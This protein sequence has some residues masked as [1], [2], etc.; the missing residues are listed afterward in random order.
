MRAVV[1]DRHGGPD[2]LRP[3]ERQ[4][5][6]PG[7][8]QVL[9]EVAAAG[10]NYIDVYHRT[11]SYPTVPPFVPGVEGAG[12]VSATGEG[13]TTPRVGDLVAW[14]GPPG[15]YAEQV[16]LPADRVVVVPDGISA[17]DAAAVMLQGLTAHYLTHATYPV[18]PGDTVLVH[19]A[20]GGVG[21][22]LI[23]VV[24]LLGGRVIGT[25]STAE[26]EDLA[27]RA[28]ADEVIRYTEVDFAERTRELTDGVG[29][30]AV[31]DGVG[32]TTFDGSMAS[33]RPRGVLALYGQASGA[34]PQLDLQR[35]NDHGSLF[36]TRP[37]LV[38]HV[39]TR[40]ELRERADAM[41]GWVADGRLTIRVG[42]RYPLAD[43][44]TAHTELEA[45][46]TTGKLLLL[47]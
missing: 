12:T 46:R 14:A 30:A 16:A 37:S 2:V 40:Q 22:L 13:V 39:A 27:R 34:V 25:V 7:P 47:P 42:H 44:A 36:V 11:G 31:Y 19:A 32:R 45:R 43:A 6:E 21:L 17:E 26:K 3:A 20:A 9:V 23:Q 28:G 24:K 33:L 38:H 4:S 8:G 29:V 10:V 5:P 15:G 18:Q 1:I 41:L 35:L